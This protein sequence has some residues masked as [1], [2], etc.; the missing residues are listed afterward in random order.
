MVHA[1]TA[2]RWAAAFAAC[3]IALGSVVSADATTF[4]AAGDQRDVVQ[5]TSEAPLE[6]I[7]GSASNVQAEVKIADLSDIVDGA[8]HAQFK[9]ELGTIDTGIALRNQHMRDMYLETEK[10]P[11]A[12]FTL[13]DVKSAQIVDESD[14]RETRKRVRGLEPGRATHV[15][16]SGT[17]ELH[18]VTRNVT[19]ED[20]S[21]TYMPASEATKMVR[22]GDL[23]AVGGSF[24]LK[25][26]DYEIERPQFVLLKLSENVDV[27]LKLVLATGVAQSDAATMACGGCGGDPCG[28]DPCGGGPCGGEPCGGNPCGS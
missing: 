6:N 3:V 7:V 5:F 22:P 13:N 20:L 19:I 10:H 27:E 23:L 21:L 15:T 2:T 16:A 25:L 1:R 12:T 18:G 14:G 4:R 24:G 17:F 11:Y 9:V 8:V 26:G 28:G